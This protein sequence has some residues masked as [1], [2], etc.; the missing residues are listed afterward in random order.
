MNRKPHQTLN[1]QNQNY[2]KVNINEQINNKIPREKH[3]IEK[4]KTK[5]PRSPNYAIGQNKKQYVPSNVHI[6]AGLHWWK[7][8]P[9][10]RTQS[11][12]A[13][14]EGFFLS[15]FVEGDGAYVAGVAPPLPAISIFHLSGAE[16]YYI[17]HFGK[18]QEKRG[19]IFRIDYSG[20]GEEYSRY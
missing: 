15:F 14:V 10:G 4:R 5:W 7:L 18:T 17:L 9:S 2:P 6:H 20:G 3:K 1:T 19:T 12:S 8:R 16:L 11:A 13:K